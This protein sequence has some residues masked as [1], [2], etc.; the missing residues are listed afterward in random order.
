[1]ASF[2]PGDVFIENLTI[3][4]PRV[5]S[6]NM[7][8][9]MLTASI[10]ETIF[11]P[12]VMGEI[13]VIDQNDYLGNFKITG[14]ELVQFQFKK[15]NGLTAKYDFHLD[16][17]KDV[18]IIGAMKSKVYKINVVS[19]E[20]LTGQANHVQKGYNTQISEMVSDIVKTGLNTK[21]KVDAEETKGKRNIKIS[22]QPALHAI[23]MLRKEAVSNKSA[24]SNYMFWQTWKGYYFQSLEYMLSQG[25]VKNFK[26]ENTVNY[27]PFTADIDS[28]IITWNVKQN[29]D[30]M[31]RIHTGALNQRVSVFN[32]HTNQFIKQ[33]VKL[34]S[35]DVPQLWQGSMIT[36]AFKSLFSSGNRS[37]LRY[38]NH[39]NDIEVGKSHVPAATAYKMLN[40]SQMQEQLLHM[41]VIGDPVLEAGK[42]IN[43][44][45][46]RVTSTTGNV[47]LD[48][49]VSG[50]W[51]IAKVEHQ[52]RGPD[53]KPRYV[54]NLECLKGAYAE[55]VE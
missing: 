44:K 12:G 10:L 21:L 40:L 4:S 51:L 19:R 42:T 50:R 28:N 53:V 27:N 6:W 35:K 13:E 34:E 1:M 45:V 26:Q 29:M 54:S 14:D 37:T 24:S 39:N 32:V 30:A 11:T 25:D 47:D 23:E 31:N 8:A 17:I 16:S 49:Q 15:P 55:K 46:P 2:N 41:T 5:A 7:A 33:D 48:P 52:I 22:N 43:A 38:V 36:A 9:N 18:K 20:V 3:V